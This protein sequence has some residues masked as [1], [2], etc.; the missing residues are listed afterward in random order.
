MST[1]LEVYF[2][3]I[4]NQSVAGAELDGGRAIRVRDRVVGPCCLSLFQQ[5]AKVA[6]QPGPASVRPAAS[7]LMIGVPVLLGVAGATGFLDYRL[8]EESDGLRRHA[9]QVEARAASELGRFA[10]LEVAVAQCAEQSAVADLRVI[11]EGLRE[12]TTQAQAALEQRIADLSSAVAAGQAATVAAV[13]P[14]VEGLTQLRVQVQAVAGDVAALRA[15]PVAAP[16]RSEEH[17]VA[18]PKPAPVASEAE[19]PAELKHHLL[20]LTDPDPG[21]RFAAVE[22][23]LSSREPRVLSGV[24]PMAKDANLFVRRLTVEGLREFRRSECVD[25]LIVALA[26][27]EAIVRF[28]AVQSLRAITGQR[29]DFDPDASLANRT[30]AQRRW[31]E[32]WEKNRATFTF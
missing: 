13:A 18:D 17:P 3:D 32:W 24:L 29:L 2:C 6:P 31:Q 1:N 26:D 19:L 21:I 10:K 9:A 14:A 22:K 11:V 30:A 7:W 4:C 25:V 23:L 27:S 5:S 16:A 12:R 15:A 8:G 28:H 20:A